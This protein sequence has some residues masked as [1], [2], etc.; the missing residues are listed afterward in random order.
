MGNS[1]YKQKHRELGLC[2]NCSAP[3]YRDRILCLKHIR[4]KNKSSK[5][6]YVNNTQKASIALERTRTMYR[7]NNKCVS[8]SAPLDPDIDDGKICCMNCRW[9]R[10]VTLNERLI[11]GT[12][13]V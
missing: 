2:E 10:H 4:S 8:C 9:H 11:H 1:K 5:Q 6:Y 3:V 13:I 7:D 12:V